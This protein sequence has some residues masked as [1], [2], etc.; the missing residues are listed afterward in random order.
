MVLFLGKEK[1]DIEKTV[2]CGIDR[3]SYE[4]TKPTAGILLYHLK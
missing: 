1:T 2:S 4:E 3:V